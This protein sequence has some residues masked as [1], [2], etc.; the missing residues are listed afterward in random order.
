MG[1]AMAF[2]ASAGGSSL[3][4]TALQGGLG[5]A[6]LIQGRRNRKSSEKQAQ[7]SREHQTS[8]RE[9]SQ[10]W[11]REQEQLEARRNLEWQAM[12]E[13]Y[14]YRTYLSPAARM[15]ALREAGLNPDLMY[16]N[17]N[18][19]G[20]QASPVNSPS[21]P[22]PQALPSAMADYSSSASLTNAGVS[23]L[24]NAAQSGL[25]LLKSRSEIK[26]NNSNVTLTG[27]QA[28]WT[29]EDRKRI[30]EQY[31][32]I[33]ADTRRIN[34]QIG[35]IFA[36]ERF[37][38]AS[39]SEK[40]QAVNE[41]VKTF[42]TRFDTMLI[43][44]RDALAELGIK[45]ADLEYLRESLADRLKSLQF[46]N[47]IS[48][49]QAMNARREWEFS[50]HWTKDSKGRQVSYAKLIYDSTVAMLDNNAA[51]LETQLDVQRKYATAH[52]IS[53]IVSEAVGS[54]TGAAFGTFFGIKTLKR[55]PL[56]EPRKRIRGFKP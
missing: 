22:T 35:E 26:L 6:Q 10:S 18:S 45:E 21:V 14:D 47:D 53:T 54:I 42:Q 49:Y 46:A 36:N 3:A 5:I 16:A 13:A 20:F 41:M 25:N 48:Q 34:A 55:A 28:E 4:Q 7:L 32:N 30:V 12:K 39:A 11:Y 56:P 9:A 8:E 1:P 40:E 50:N 27:A 17:G 37:L 52:A 51:L 19:V 31:N 43:N 29:K 2:L 38:K 23:T 15:A 24:S 44:Q 33:A